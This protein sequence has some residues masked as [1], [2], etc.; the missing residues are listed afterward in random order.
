MCLKPSIHV[1]QRMFLKL[2]VTGKI[3]NTVNTKKESS[4]SP[5]HNNQFPDCCINV[6]PVILDAQAPIVAVEKNVSLCA[7]VV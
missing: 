3:V 7:R 4:T 2:N 1:L 5:L 6:L